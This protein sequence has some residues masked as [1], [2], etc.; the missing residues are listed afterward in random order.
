MPLTGKSF[1]CDKLIHSSSSED[2]EIVDFI[3]TSFYL[4]PLDGAMKGLAWND[5]NTFSLTSHDTIPSNI[6]QV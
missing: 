2:N 5:K 3:S 6:W 4:L 1:C